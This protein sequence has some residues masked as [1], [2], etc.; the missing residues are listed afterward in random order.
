MAIVTENY[1]EED[2]RIFK[3]TY[4]DSGFVIRQIET[5]FCFAEAIDPHDA[6]WTYEET[7]DPID[8]GEDLSKDDNPLDYSA[9]DLVAA[10]KI[11]LGEIE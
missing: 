7:N 5:G 6:T 11:L 1:F 4:S 2:G 3:K 10:A 9:Q 8:W